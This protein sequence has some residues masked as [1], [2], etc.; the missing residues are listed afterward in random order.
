MIVCDLNSGE[1]PS[2]YAEVAVLSGILEFLTTA[3]ILIEHVCKKTERKIIL[4]YITLEKF[5][6]KAG[7]HASAYVNNF[8]KQQIIGMLLKSGFELK[9]MHTDPSHDI[10]TMFLFEK[11]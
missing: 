2:V 6:D 5:S 8:T 10:N 7:R 11:T 3:E 4:S 9:E 1:F